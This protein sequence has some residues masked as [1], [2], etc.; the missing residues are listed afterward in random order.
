MN[1]ASRVFLFAYFVSLAIAQPTDLVFETEEDLQMFFSEEMGT[2][3]VD[4]GD[5]FRI[6]H[7]VTGDVNAIGFF[8]KK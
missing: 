3:Y 7:L 2:G 4:Y 1:G 6:G 8:A 5:V